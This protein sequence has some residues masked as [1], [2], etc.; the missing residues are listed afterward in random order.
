MFVVA[1]YLVII[2]KDAAEIE[3]TGR[4]K[5]GRDLLGLPCAG[6]VLHL[7]TVHH[8]Q[9]GGDLKGALGLGL[10]L[11]RQISGLGC[12]LVWGLFRGL[13]LGI[14]GHKHRLLL[15]LRLLLLGEGVVR[16]WWL[17]TVRDSGR[18]G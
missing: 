6:D 18:R 11:R 3:E 5:V 12:R 7:R 14:K 16:P 15:L 10:R 9:I 17:H 1:A 13:L 2:L 8:A 4:T